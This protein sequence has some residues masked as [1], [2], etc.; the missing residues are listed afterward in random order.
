[1][2]AVMENS[3]SVKCGVFLDCKLLKKISA[4]WSQLVT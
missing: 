4:P 2:G 1:M 3:L